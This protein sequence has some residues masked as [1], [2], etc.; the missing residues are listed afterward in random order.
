MIFSKECRS[1]FVPTYASINILDN[2]KEKETIITSN[3]KVAQSIKNILGVGGNLSS[4][5]YFHALKIAKKSILE[6]PFGWGINRY[7]VAFN[8]YNEKSLKS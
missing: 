5:I 4:R 7:N 8:Y 1:R 2:T 6:K 3:S